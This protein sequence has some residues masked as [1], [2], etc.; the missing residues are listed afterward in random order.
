[1]YGARILILTTE[2]TILELNKMKFL[3][4]NHGTLQ[5]SRNYYTLLNEQHFETCVS[6]GIRARLN[7][8]TFT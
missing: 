5:T 3:Q 6:G 4:L 8:A 7:M 1:M 2:V